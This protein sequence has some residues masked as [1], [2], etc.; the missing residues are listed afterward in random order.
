MTERQPNA[1]LA[2]ATVHDPVPDR[3][4]TAVIAYKARATAVDKARAASCAAWRLLRWCL[5]RGTRR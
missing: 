3:A 5:R 2:T 4:T 1:P